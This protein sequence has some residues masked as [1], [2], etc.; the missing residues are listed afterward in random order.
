MSEDLREYR[1]ELALYCITRETR[2]VSAADLAETMGTLA[3]REGHPKACFA[4]LDGVEVAGILRVLR[5]TGRVVNT[6]AIHS[7]A[8]ARSVPM[9]RAADGEERSPMPLPPDDEDLAPSPRVS[10]PA[11]DLRTEAMLTVGDMTAAFLA[12]QRADREAFERE[13]LRKHMEFT[14]RARDTLARAGVEVPS[15]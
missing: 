8:H 12:Q 5:S 1:R 13:Q 11:V 15:A 6:A 10:A 2:P 4:R 7:S 14:A 3:M 9:W